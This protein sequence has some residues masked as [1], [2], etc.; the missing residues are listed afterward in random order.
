VPRPAH[1]LESYGL[2]VGVASLVIS[3]SALPGSLALAA[4]VHGESMAVDRTVRRLG[5]E[6][7]L[8]FLQA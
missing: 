7:P 5:S 4:V 2:V 6:A 3:R 8:L 1:D